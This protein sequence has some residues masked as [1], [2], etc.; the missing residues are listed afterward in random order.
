MHAA[1]CCSTF[2]QQYIVHIHGVDG[3]HGVAHTQQRT[4]QITAAYDAKGQFT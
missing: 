2:V 1:N 3:I 4:L